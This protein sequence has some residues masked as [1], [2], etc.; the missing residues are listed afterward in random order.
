MDLKLGFEMRNHRIHRK[1]NK[2]RGEEKL[3][4]N[5]RDRNRIRVLLASSLL[6]MRKSG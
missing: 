3:V 1:I 2:G 5:D 6:R 4:I